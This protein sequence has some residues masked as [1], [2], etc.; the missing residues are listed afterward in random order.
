MGAFKDL[1]GQIFSKLTAIAL[2]DRRGGSGKI[3]WVCICEC[4]NIVETTSNSLMRGDI[5][6]CGC[7]HIKDLTGQRFGRLTVISLSD[8]K[9]EYSRS[10]V[11]LCRCDCGN[12]IITSSTCLKSGDTLSCGCLHRE[13]MSE[14]GKARTTHGLRHTPEYDAWSNMK[15]RCCS[16]N[17]R[18]YK[19]YGGRGIS[20]CDRW[21]NSFENF[22]ADMGLKPSPDHSIDRIDNDGNYEP[23][24]CRWATAEEQSNNRRNIVRYSYNGG[25]YTYTQLARIFDISEEPLRQKLIAGWPVEKAIELMVNN[26]HGSK[27]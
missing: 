4:G 14:V 10:A 1:T 3:M 25:D 18:D 13:I 22:Y 21:L 6:S 15:R 8:K 2:S 12:E 5:T 20:V 27:K 24:N 23:N 7:G 17:G 16:E 19:N 11:W 26:R 9:L